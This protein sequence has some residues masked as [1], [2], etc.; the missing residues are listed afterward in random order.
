LRTYVD[1]MTRTSHFNIIFLFF[2]CNNCL[3]S[4]VLRRN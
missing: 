1:K 4:L 2:L 3:Y